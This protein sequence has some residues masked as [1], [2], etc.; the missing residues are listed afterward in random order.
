[1]EASDQPSKHFN[2]RLVAAARM[3]QADL[4][5]IDLLNRR[6]DGSRI[7]LIV[8]KYENLTIRLDASTNHRRPHL[9]ID[10]KKNHHAASYA[11]DT[12]ERLAGEPTRYDKAIA[13]WILANQD[14]LNTTWY[15]LRQS[16][17]NDVIV[18]SLNGSDFG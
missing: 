13:K 8:R 3:L 6:W 10:Y 2:D 11:I 14:D 12:G 16:S 4:A 15:D 18:A 5:Q 9:H 7:E 17:A 1:M